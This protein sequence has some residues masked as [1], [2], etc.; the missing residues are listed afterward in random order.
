MTAFYMMA[1][2]AFNEVIL[3]IYSNKQNATSQIHQTKRNSTNCKE[4]IVE[5]Y[6]NLES[7]IQHS[8]LKQKIIQYANGYSFMV[9]IYG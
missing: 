3:A 4:M 5:N 9:V 2:L 6:S 7:L 8:I 1:T